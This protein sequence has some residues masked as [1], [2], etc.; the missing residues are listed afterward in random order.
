MTSHFRRS[1]RPRYRSSTTYFS[2][3]LEVIDIAKI[4]R[5]HMTPLLPSSMYSIE[6]QSNDDKYLFE[7]NSPLIGK[8]IQF[9]KV[10]D[11]EQEDDEV[12]FEVQSIRSIKSTCTPWFTR[13]TDADTDIIENETPGRIEDSTN[14]WLFVRDWT[15]NLSIEG[16]KRQW[17]HFIISLSVLLIQILA[18]FQLT[19]YL[20][21]S[22]TAEDQDTRNNCYGP[23]CALPHPHCMYFFTG[24]NAGVLLLGFLWADVI[25]TITMIKDCFNTTHDEK[26][27]KTQLIA[28]AVILIEITIAIICGI[29][30]GV[31]T[32]SRFDAIN[33]AVG[34]LFVHDLDEQVFAAMGYIGSNWKKLLALVLWIALAIVLAL[35]AACVF[36]DGS[37]V[38]SGDNKCRTNEFKCAD[39]TCIWYGL[40]C[41][42]VTDCADGE[43]ETS[44]QMQCDYSLIQCPEDKFMCLSTG[45][46]ID[47]TKRCNG[48]LD[49]DDGSDENHAQSCS[50]QIAAI[51]CNADNHGFPLFEQKYENDEWYHKISSIGYYKCNNGQCIDAQ[52]LCDGIAGDCVDGSDEWPIYDKVVT[53]WPYLKQCPYARLIECESDQILCKINGKCISLMRQCD[54]VNDCPDA[55]DEL[56]CDKTQSTPFNCAGYP[57]VDQFQCGGAIALINE[58][59]YVLFEN[60][61]V[62]PYIDKASIVRD[63]TRGTSFYPEP[64]G[65]CVP[66]QYRCD[67]I[68]D[69]HDGSDE[70]MCYLFE[71]G[72]D[73]FQCRSG[74]CIPKEWQCD[75]YPD[76]WQ[77]EDEMNCDGTLTSEHRGMVT[78]NLY[79]NQFAMGSITKSNSQT[80]HLYNVFVPCAEGYKAVR[81][82]TCNNKTLTL[83]TVMFVYDAELNTWYN[84]QA[85]CNIHNFYASSVTINSDQLQCDMLYSV[86][87]SGKY[88]KETYGDFGLEV[89]C[90]HTDFK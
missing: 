37:F 12:T 34:I 55:Q 38:G 75:E 11:I 13:E 17:T 26:L 89:T 6:E 3:V 62:I 40:V 20:M 51:E 64:A 54:G 88:F 23:H 87:I 25:A 58:T 41:N 14:Q 70:E 39:G 32:E 30:I 53:E 9:K 45:T 74:Y 86:L 36:S 77:K 71:C 72:A 44:Q 21:S 60:A 78:H 47:G 52:Y 48:I 43:D 68:V 73:Q 29:L 24:V 35:P 56:S 7:F 80:Q 19:Y 59:H 2:K 5:T 81:F 61:T 79:C 4:P 83:N 31:F 66:W 8:R 65:E 69:C 28:S 1:S 22:V 10:E 15:F 49:C 46:C 57:G 76:C 27:N 85:G 84:D 18:Y 33:G 67:G 50:V 42:G 82:T 63:I 90:S 16:N